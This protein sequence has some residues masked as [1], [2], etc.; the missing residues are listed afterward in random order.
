MNLKATL[1]PVQN[2]RAVQNIG[3]KGGSGSTTWDKVKDKPF[4]TLGEDFVV[5]DG[6]LGLGAVPVGSVDWDNIED[7]PNFSTVATTGD[8]NDLS[9]TP[10][11]PVADGTTIIDNN[12]VWSAVGST[13]TLEIDN[14]SLVVDAETGKIREAVPVWTE[15]IEHQIVTESISDFLTRDSI[16]TNTWKRSGV[17]DDYHEYDG[18]NPYVSLKVYYG[19]TFDE[20][21]LFSGRLSSTY[22]LEDNTKVYTD[23]NHR[24]WKCYIQ[25]N[26]LTIQCLEQEVI[27]PNDE[28][29]DE[30]LCRLEVSWLDY[31][32]TEY[33]YYNWYG[34]RQGI[35]LNTWTCVGDYSDIISSIYN[36]NIDY[37]E[38]NR[39][40]FV[41]NIED[42][43]YSVSADNYDFDISPIIT[44]ENNLRWQ[45]NYSSP[46]EDGKI[47]VTCLDTLPA[48]FNSLND[49]SVTIREETSG[50]IIH[51]LPAQYV[52]I[53]NDT[54]INDN[55][56][57]KAVDSGSNVSVNQILSSGTAIADITV[58]GA[59]TTL[60]APSGGS[61]NIDNKSLVE[62]SGVIQEAV[63]LYNETTSIT[64]TYG[65]GL[66]FDT[67]N[68]PAG[69]DLDCF[70]YTNGNDITLDTSTTAYD[71]VLSIDGTLDTGT[72]NAGYSASP[73]SY[74]GG[75]GSLSMNTFGGGF[76][77]YWSYEELQGGEYGY[78]VHVYLGGAYIQ[79]G[80][81]DFLMIIPQ[82]PNDTLEVQLSTLGLSNMWKTHTNTVTET[83][84]HKLPS[85]YYDKVKCKDD[86]LRSAVRVV[87]GELR[88]AVISAG[89][90]LHMM[91]TTDDDG[92]PYMVLSAD[93]PI[94]DAGGCL[95]NGSY[96]TGFW[97]V[98]GETY[99]TNKQRLYTD[100]FFGIFDAW[101]VGDYIFN[102]KYCLLP[103]STS[104]LSIKGILH[105]GDVRTD[106]TDISIEGWESILDDF[107]WDSTNNRWNMD[108]KEG[109]SPRGM[110]GLYLYTMNEDYGKQNINAF[111]IPVDNNTIKTNS[112]GQLE[113]A[114]PAPPAVNGTYTLQAVVSNGTITYSWI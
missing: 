41:Y 27:E 58:D 73:P 79:T 14:Q 33:R 7:K 105:L 71:I 50:Q 72:W 110:D 30:L 15:N 66:Y 96:E 97:N 16:K 83:I 98:G 75:Y 2:L 109:I 100:D 84:Y 13:P 114:I 90:N 32:T 65:P 53:D 45:V 38:V 55:G 36:D 19:S 51:Q 5:E 40:E 63:P 56:I 70:L 93:K 37:P 54:I 18:Y 1:T 111:Y 9:N 29:Y 89:D 94:Q 59:T 48:G 67:F 85:E 20:E 31:D 78:R 87:D 95:I 64:T 35:E 68:Y 57:L 62:V 80:N 81:V 103:N 44:D 11:I 6:V 42:D 99:A 102:E 107:Y 12:G 3:G 4:E 26:E 10:T 21:V 28:H 24:D 61:V 60:Y 76:E 106:P 86:E 52:P 47:T 25:N 92:Y 49:I 17:Y 108:F 69:N 46:L 112:D 91:A 22:D 43:S 113:T 23:N 82:D 104:G 39:I 34:V 88:A 77:L 8:Y 101:G 74:Y